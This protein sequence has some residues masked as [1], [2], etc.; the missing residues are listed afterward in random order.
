MVLGVSEGRVVTDYTIERGVGVRERMNLL[1]ALNGPA[2]LVLIDILGVAAGWACLDLGC[3]GGHVATAVGAAS[4]PDRPAGMVRARVLLGQC[5][6][7]TRCNLP[8]C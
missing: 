2:T 4:T 1:A 6:M 7:V 8:I 5:T 3:G